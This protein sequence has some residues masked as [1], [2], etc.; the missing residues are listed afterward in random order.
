MICGLRRWSTLGRGLTALSFSSGYL[1]DPYTESR[2]RKLRSGSSAVKARPFGFGEGRAAV[3][4]VAVLGAGLAG[5][6]AARDLVRGGADVVVLEARSRVGG[7][8][9]ATTL[10]DGRTVQLGGEVIGHKHTGYLELL[11]ELG[12]SAQPS[13][14]ARPG[15]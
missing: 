15:G 1:R 11:G 5:L 14:R 8:V 6:S 4:D 2:V 3:T 13:H 7:R 12:P 9:D 10:P